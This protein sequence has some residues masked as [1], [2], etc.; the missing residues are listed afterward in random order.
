MKLPNLTELFKKNFLSLFLLFCVIILVLFIYDFPVIFAFFYTPKG[1]VFLG[2]NS[3]FEPW[4]YNLYVSAIHF[5]QWG[6]ILLPNQYTSFPNNPIL[7]YPL[8]TLVGFIFKTVSPFLL[9][10]LGNITS[11]IILLIVFYILIRKLGFSS[12]TSLIA[13]LTISL[14]GGIGFLSGKSFNSADLTSSL[15]TF[16]STFEKMHEAVGVLFFT[17]ALV[18]FF[19]FTV[20]KEKLRQVIFIL[21]FLI[22]S[23]FIY[24]YTILPFF[25]IT[26]VFVLVYRKGKINFFDSKVFAIL[27]T[28]AILEVF[29]LFKELSSNLTFA[30]ISAHIIISIIPLF[31][32]YG[33]LVPLFLY[34]IFFLPKTPIKIFLSIWFI[35][36]FLLGV[37]PIGPGRVF[38]RGSFF[39]ITLVS[40]LTLIELIKKFRLNKYVIFAIFIFFLTGTSVFIFLNQ[41]NSSNANNSW[42]YMPANDFKVFN[43]LTNNTPPNS[44]VLTLSLLSNQ[45]PAFTKNRVFYGNPT[46]SRYFNIDRQISIVFFLGQLNQKDEKNFLVQNNISYILIGETEKNLRKQYAKKG[47][48]FSKIINS[49]QKVFQSDNI[50]LYKVQ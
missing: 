27:L 20:N 25:I 22:G 23:I 44:A 50:S 15:V 31:L 32:G 34:Q 12:N 39:P 49:F 6:G 46:Q 10:F 8:L 41:I 24:P 38:L 37:F 7:L 35:T 16:Y 43:Y 30:G 21:I 47:D 2:Q 33:I 42:V 19:L 11:G 1:F 14:G 28:P 9:F 13:L 5:G 29:F 36:V 3:Y 26:G 45:I 48:S 4:D 18:S 17:L 40:I